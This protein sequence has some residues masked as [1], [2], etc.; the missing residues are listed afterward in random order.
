M[1]LTSFW[2]DLSIRKKLTIPCVT[3]NLLLLFTGGYIYWSASGLA[4]DISTLQ[5]DSLTRAFK[6]RTLKE[7]II[8]IQQW[9]TDMAA[10]RGAEG[11]DDGFAQAERYYNHA[12]GLINEAITDHE[13]S[14]HHE[15]AQKLRKFRDDLESY[16]EMGKKM[17]SAYIEGGPAK[18]NSV[19]DQFDP[20]ASRLSEEIGEF[21]NDK[22]EALKDSIGAL[23]ATTEGIGKEIVTVFVCVFLF[24]AIFAQLTTGNIIASINDA[25]AFIQ[26]VASGDLTAN[27]KVKSRDE[28]GQLCSAMNRMVENLRKMVG[29]S[30]TSLVDFDKKSDDLN[31]LAQDLRRLSQR[32]RGLV[33]EM[34][35]GMVTA[36]ENVGSVAAAMEE[37]TATISEISANTAETKNISMMAKEDAEGAQ[38][39]I[40]RLVESSQKIEE[41]SKLIGSIA[42]QTNLLALNATIEAARAGEAGKGFAVV[43]NEV[44]ELAKQTSDSIVEIDEVIRD[45]V[46]GSHKASDAVKLIVDTIEKVAEYSDSVAASVEEQSATTNEVS[47]RSQE[48]SMEVSRVSGL[49]D[50]IVQGGEDT[51]R[52]AEMILETAQGIKERSARLEEDISAFRV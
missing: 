28:I 1:S 50:D 43:A 44:K 20:Y 37:M 34:K 18:G 42:E 33:E 16:Y 19:M 12:L 48:A 3:I 38:E 52:M 9:L 5:N 30:F 32:S 21:I 23:K 31:Q 45:I 35:E 51:I 46:Q 10:T 24:S 8:Q 40:A 25:F 6:Y 49:T 14:G 39:V 27:V 41:V 17:A 7:D 26:K 11:Y 13:K 47:S 22:E 15:T 36:N 29:D 2:N 4:R